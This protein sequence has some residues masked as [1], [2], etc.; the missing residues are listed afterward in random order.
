M[1]ET[2]RSDMIVK[3]N[4]AVEM[5]MVEI[6]KLDEAETVIIEDS[7]DRAPYQGR[8]GTKPDSLI[9]TIQIHLHH[10]TRHVFMSLQLHLYRS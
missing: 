10:N 2:S 1:S 5:L 7:D 6:A 3:S 9:Q 4:K 8:M